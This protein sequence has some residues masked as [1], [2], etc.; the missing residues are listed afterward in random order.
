MKMKVA[1]SPEEIKWLHFEMPLPR[2]L[3]D[4]PTPLSDSQNCLP[5]SPTPFPRYYCEHA[6]NVTHDIFS[7]IFLLALIFL[8][9]VR[10]E[11]EPRIIFLFGGVGP[12]PP[13]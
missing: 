12:L 11:R 6:K 3:P 10:T 4:G 1:A 7:D 8:R 13:P 2:R 9:G 5:K